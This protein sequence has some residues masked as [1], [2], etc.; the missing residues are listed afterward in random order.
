MTRLIRNC[1][2]PVESAHDEGFDD[3]RATDPSLLPDEAAD[4]GVH[5]DTRGAP[6]GDQQGRVSHHAVPT[7][8]SRLRRRPN[9]KATNP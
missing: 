8:I 6:G 5:D 2:Q 4:D 9:P 7:V 3:E 1:D